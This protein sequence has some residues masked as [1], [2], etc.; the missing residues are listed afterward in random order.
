MLLPLGPTGSNIFSRAARFFREVLG[1]LSQDQKI[2]QLFTALHT[3]K[4]SEPSLVAAVIQDL[5]ADTLGDKARKVAGPIAEL[6]DTMFTGAT[7][8]LRDTNIDALTELADMFHRATGPW[9]R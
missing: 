8:R 3:G 5:K 9:R 2:D 7:D 6:A 1:V 4:F